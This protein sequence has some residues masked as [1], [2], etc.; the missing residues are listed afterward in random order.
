[1]LNTYTVERISTRMQSSPRR[2]IHEVAKDTKSY[3]DFAH[4]QKISEIR[5]LDPCSNQSTS[6]IV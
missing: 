6:V 5:E 3:L 1:L 4:M 2:H